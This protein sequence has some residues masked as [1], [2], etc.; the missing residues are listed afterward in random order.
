MRNLTKRELEF[1]LRDAVPRF[2]N[3][4]HS[5]EYGIILAPFTHASLRSFKV[6]SVILLSLSSFNFSIC[7]FLLSGALLAYSLA[8]S[9]SLLINFFTI[10]PPCVSSRNGTVPDRGTRSGETP[11]GGRAAGRRDPLLIC[12]CILSQKGQ[13]RALL[14]AKTRVITH[15]SGES[16]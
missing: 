15:V 10:W 5:S 14:N 9:F 2:Y 7:C 4:T 1:L 8:E 11:R 13:A 6:F 12:R 3:R 16:G